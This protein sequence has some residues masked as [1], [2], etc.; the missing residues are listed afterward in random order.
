VQD[1][2]SAD[3]IARLLA[4]VCR[5][6]MRVI[7]GAGPQDLSAELRRFEHPSTSSTRP[8]AP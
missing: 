6:H 4:D 3:D 7:A 5:V 8:S 1:R 2:Y